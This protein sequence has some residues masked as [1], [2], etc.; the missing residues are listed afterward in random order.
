MDQSDFSFVPPNYDNHNEDDKNGARF[1]WKAHCMLLVG[2]VIA[3]RCGW[4]RFSGGQKSASSLSPYNHHHHHHPY[5]A[6]PQQNLH[7]IELQHQKSSSFWKKNTGCRA[8][9]PPSSTVA[10]MGHVVTMLPAYHNTAP[11]TTP[12]PLSTTI[13]VVGAPTATG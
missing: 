2:V 8:N 11:T 4:L 12:A 7:D 5:A 13:P 6:V 9:V 1:G 3:L 10:A